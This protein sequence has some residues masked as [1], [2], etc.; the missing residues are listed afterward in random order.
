MVSADNYRKDCIYWV[1]KKVHSNP[2][3]LAN[4][5]VGAEGGHV[6]GP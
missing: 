3:F 5:I 6:K 4:S 1:G 2:N